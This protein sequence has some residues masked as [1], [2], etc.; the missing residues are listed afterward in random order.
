MMVTLTSHGQLTLPK[1]IRDGP[2]P[3]AGAERD[4]VVDKHGTERVRPLRPLPSLC[5]LLH[6]PGVKPL[7]LT[8]IDTAIR[9][10]VSAEDRRIKERAASSQK[11]VGR[12]S[13]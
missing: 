4:V 3:H 6:R 11:R 12:S 9:G 7:T 10:Y 1:A 5:G 13:R 8:D 2:Q